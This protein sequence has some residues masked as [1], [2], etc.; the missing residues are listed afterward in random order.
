MENLEE[1]VCNIKFESCY[2]PRK[3]QS[4]VKITFRSMIWHLGFKQKVELFIMW[5]K[6][7][8][9]GTERV[10]FKIFLDTERP[11]EYGEPIFIEVSK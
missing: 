10:S 4:E 3:E 1:C 7:Y 8:F 6:C 11:F 9:K 2:I 5:V